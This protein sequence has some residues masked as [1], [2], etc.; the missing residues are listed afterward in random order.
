MTKHFLYILA[1]ACCSIAAQGQ[2]VAINEDGSAPNANAMLDVKSF[3][4]GVLLPRLGTA[5]RTAIAPVKGILVFDTATLTYWYGNGTAWV[6]I[7]A[8]AGGPWLLNGN[9]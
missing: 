8:T 4:K 2:N 1:L 3:N 9:S 7:N 5:A 6:N